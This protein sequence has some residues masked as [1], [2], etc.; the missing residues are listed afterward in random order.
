LRVSKLDS[1]ISQYM[2]PSQAAYDQQ[3]KHASLV[4]S[5]RGRYMHMSA[6]ESTGMGPRFKDDIRWREIYEG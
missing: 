6:K 4:N 2:A 5:L 1:Q 3:V